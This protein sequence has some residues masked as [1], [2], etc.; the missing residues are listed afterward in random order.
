MVSIKAGY[1]YMRALPGQVQQCC[2]LTKIED[3]AP[4][5]LPYFTHS[6]PSPPHQ[7]FMNTAT[8]GASADVGKITSSGLKRMLGPAAFLFTGERGPPPPSHPF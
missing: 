1:L 8:I 2:K 3:T 5:L 6:I 4:P 7:V